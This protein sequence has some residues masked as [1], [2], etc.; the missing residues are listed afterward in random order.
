M[1]A[2]SS[3]PRSRPRSSPSTTAETSR[4]V[5]VSSVAAGRALRRPS[6][7]P[8]AWTCSRGGVAAAPSR[9]RRPPRARPTGACPRRAA[10]R[11]R[12][13]RVVPAPGQ[14]RHQLRAPGAGAPGG[15]GAR[16]RAGRA[17]RPRDVRR[18]PGD[19]AAAPPAVLRR[20]PD[21]AGD[22]APAARR[23][24]SGSGPTSCTSPHPPRSACRRRG[25]R[26]ELGIPTVAIYQTDL[27]G[28]AEQYGV[29]GGARACDDVLTRTD[30]HAGSTARWRPPPRASRSSV[31]SDVHA[32]GPLATRRRPGA[33]PHRRA[34]TRACTRA[35]PRR[36]P[37]RRA[38]SAGWPRRRSWS[39]WPTSTGTPACAS[40]SSAAGPEEAR[41]RALLPDAAF[42]GVLHGEE[43][44]ARPRLA[45]RVR[46]HRAPRDVLPVGPG[47][48]GQSGVPVVAPRS[49]GPIDVVHD[50][51]AGFLYEPGDGADLGGPRRAAGRAPGVPPPDGRWRPA[52]GAGPVVAGGQRGPGRPLPR[53]QRRPST[54]CRAG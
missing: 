29:P 47:G 43:L 3:P 21:R 4:S 45:R 38:T 25:R 17:D 50:G 53:G 30:P 46:A 32:A 28:F 6:L 27:V 36:Q 18:V 24:C 39:C 33:V 20:L 1:P 2:A 19:P 40:C 11:A 12:R 34:A 54:G 31:G 7:R 16:G 37:P 35:R 14:R 23:P 15:R 10:P 22:P 49:G 42:L 8:R 13:H 48:A 44:G 5:H 26:D 51:V 9:Y 41:L 52:R